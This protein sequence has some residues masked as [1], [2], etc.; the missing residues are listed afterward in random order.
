MKNAN[1]TYTKHTYI[2][3]DIQWSAAGLDCLSVLYVLCKW[4]LL[5]WPRNARSVVSVRWR[6]QWHTST[7]LWCRP[8]SVVRKL[9]LLLLLLVSLSL[10]PLCFR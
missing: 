1:R 9:L 6:Q 5:C 8:P 10:I 2:H 7:I 4:S 3:V